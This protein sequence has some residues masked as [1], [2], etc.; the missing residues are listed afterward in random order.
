MP[1]SPQEAATLAS[2]GSN[3]PALQQWMR[4]GDWGEIADWYNS[5]PQPTLVGMICL[6]SSEVLEVYTIFLYTVELT[7]SLA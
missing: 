6:A 5:I 4:E 2:H 1:L 7:S 3:H